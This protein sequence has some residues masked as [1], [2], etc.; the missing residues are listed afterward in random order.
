MD[1]FPKK[2][3]NLILHKMETNIFEIVLKIILQGWFINYLDS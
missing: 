2:C 1:F 3:E